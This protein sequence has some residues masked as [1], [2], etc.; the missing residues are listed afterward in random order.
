M[1]RFIPAILMA[2]ALVSA[3]DT[4]KAGV[5]Q[6]NL[7]MPLQGSQEDS[8]FY[9]VSLQYAS[10]GLTIPAM[11][12]MNAAIVDM[13]FDMENAESSASLEEAAAQYRENLI[14]E[15]ITENAGMVGRLPVLT[16]EDSIT[17]EFTG[18]FRNWR[19]YQI[20][21]YFY[22]GGAHGSS[23]CALMV[24]DA[25]TGDVLTED[26]LFTDWYFE[27]VADLMRE[28]V[29]ADLEAQNPEALEILDMDQIVPNTNFS[30]GPDGVMWLF[31]PDDLLP[32]AFG[33]L[34]ITVPWDCLKPYLR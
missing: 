12:K 13:A 22:R 4:F 31:Q 29:K 14:D 6:D 19:N 5:Y 3:C 26:A 10:A 17:G 7:I 16:W 8:L 9:N 32:H 33:P 23:T 28:S 2:L 21:F 1:K 20:N 24:F 34:C 27:K 25:K 18:K 11:E 30:V 15:Y